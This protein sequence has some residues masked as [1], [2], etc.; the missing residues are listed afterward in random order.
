M[1]MVSVAAL[2]ARLS[3]YLRLVA[4]GEEVVV[5]SHRERIARILP[6]E[7]HKPM[8]QLA[9]RPVAELRRIKGLG[10]RR[11][12]SAVEELIRDRRSR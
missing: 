12:V 3:H 4:R 6:V 11:S 5:T 9:S 10:A 2:K 8:L 7:G 1:N